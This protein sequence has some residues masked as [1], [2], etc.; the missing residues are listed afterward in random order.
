MDKILG[1]D[2]AGRDDTYSDRYKYPY[3][4][5]PYEVL[6]RLTESGLIKETDIVLD[7]G[8]GKGRVEFFLQIKLD[9]RSLE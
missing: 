3:E 6:E 2:T 9:V 1:I 4:P 7:Y 8:C 5:T